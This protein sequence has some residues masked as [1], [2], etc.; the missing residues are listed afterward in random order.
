MAASLWNDF[1][2]LQFGNFADVTADQQ[3]AAYAR[4]NAA[5]VFHP[6]G[7]AFMSPVNATNGVANPDLTVKDT[8][9][10]RVIDASIFVSDRES[11]CRSGW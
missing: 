6:V 4:N 2:L 5:S 8:V 11:V 10:L 7:T 3:I 9:G 1:V